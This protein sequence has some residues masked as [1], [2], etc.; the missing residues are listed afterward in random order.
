MRKDL[1]V[2]LVALFAMHCLPMTSGLWSQALQNSI[3]GEVRDNSN[4][5]VPDAAV[6]VT[7]QATNVSRRVTTDATGHYTIPSLV[8][9]EYTVRLEHPGFKTEVRRG[10]VV[11]A[12]QS[13]RVDFA[14]SVGEITESIEVRADTTAPLIRT[15][16]AAMGLV[17]S[18]TQ[19]RGLPLK[20]RNFAALAAIVPGTTEAL[21]GNQNDLGRTQTLN[22]SANG[23][24]HFDNN[25]RLDG[26][27]FINAFVN[28]STFIPSLETLQEV[29][30]ETGQYSA[31]LGSYSGAQV[32][33]VVKSGGNDFHGSVFEFLR[34]DALNARQFFDLRDPPPFR[35]NQFGATVGGPINIPGLYKGK[36]RTFFFFGYEGSRIRRQE[37]R[38][39]TVASDAMRRGD[40]SELLPN[41]VIVDP[42][43]KQ[44]FPGNR[45]DSSRIASQALKLIEFIP[46]ETNPGRPQ[47]FINTASDVQDE[48]QYIGR[49]DH[50]L[51]ASDTIFVRAAI[52]NADFR[53]VTINPSFQSLGSPRNQNYVLS[54]THI[55]S[56]RVIN[57]FKVS[58]VRESIPTK[59]GREGADI[60]PLRD[61]GIK[62]IAFGDPLVVGIP[63]A[64][65]S[66]F[67]GTGENFANPRLLY[68]APA[69]QNH[70]QVQ[71]TGHT[72]SF[73]AE[74]FR[75][76]QDFF[77]V[78]AN[79]QGLFSF[80]GRLTGNA[81]A[82]FLLGLPEQTIKADV[83]PRS[84]IHQ[85]HFGAYLQDDWRATSRLTLNLGLRYEFAGPYRDQLGQARNF[86]WKTLAQFPEPGMT[87]DLNDASHNLAP[88]FGFAYR[89]SN[90]TVIRGGFGIFFTLPTTANVNLLNRNPPLN[91]MKQFFTDLNAPDLTLEDG[92]RI[93]KLQTAPPRPPDILTIPIDYGPGY[94]QMW[95]FNI[96]QGLPGGWVG[97][98]GYAGS[99][100]L[101]LDNAHTDN[102]PL[103][104]GP[105][106]VQ[107]RRPIA[108][109]A[110]IRVFGTDGVAYYNALQTRLQS[111][112]WHGL[113]F[114]T[115]Y[116]WSKCIDT[117][118]SAA[119]S[120]VGSEDQE[121]QNQYDRHVAERGRC[122]ID[123]SHVFKIHSV[124]DIPLGKRLTG[125]A[126]HFLKDW[127]LSTSLNLHNGSPFTI[128]V[129]GNP[130]NTGRGTIRASRT[131]D[132][133]LPP[134]QRRP[135]RWFDTG[136]FVQPPSFTFGNSGRGVV[137]GPATK[138]LD[139]SLI[140]QINFTERNK[141]QFRT[142]F[143]NSL[144]T[145]QF[146]IPGRVAG[147]PA[148]GRITETGRAREIQFGL[149]YLF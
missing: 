103:T 55:F 91:D 142:D 72:L 138:L 135:E 134:S 92:F 105:G 106:A 27:S 129:P 2:I 46:R 113:N 37:T 42:F 64:N 145:P 69:V 43:T 82:D 38:Q 94:A 117:K 61:F 39:G 85:R 31:A 32:N 148:F 108:R 146:L 127:Q 17:V 141:L 48:N 120:T 126:G 149:R 26:V 114:L 119:T 84:S 45:I 86:D 59:T 3:V 143:F 68:S 132:G 66:G 88:R 10:V 36:D 95:N 93:E 131:A 8:V 130:A 87:A 125:A 137:E 98:I 11:Q 6:T 56:P 80:T 102:N 74:F 89:L 67:I 20:G 24:R 16:S 107:D 41:R 19:V 109:F 60:D 21:S 78:N 29:N 81:F 116:S 77:S 133:N 12:D 51:S 136:A 44:P 14:L 53:Q 15:E 118:S 33:M 75:R 25:Y 52:R 65:I 121:P 13:L 73:G 124:Y 47:N 49:V 30:V 115:S 110:S 50:N 34:N 58:Y 70:L 83:S 90:T 100:T 7:H 9:G 104:P 28:G 54:E 35:F 76:R 140:K 62:G 97:E 40:L 99:H 71:L 139:F 57:E 5:V 101:G 18:Q 1:A 128:I 79:N 111:R 122:V 23:Q 112:A 63:S 4:A 147:T 96:Q 22:L 144:N 123:F